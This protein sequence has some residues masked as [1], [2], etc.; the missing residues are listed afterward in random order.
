MSSKIHN[1]GCD[2]RPCDI[3]E[4]ATSDEWIVTGTV[5]TENGMYYEYTIQNLALVSLTCSG[6]E[7][8]DQAFRNMVFAE[9]C[10]RYL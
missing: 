8:A 4:H 6:V 3:L 10:S 5:I 9:W 2:T 1:I 7:V